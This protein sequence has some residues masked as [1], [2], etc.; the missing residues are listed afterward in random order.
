MRLISWNLAGRKARVSDQVT[1]LAARKPAVVALQEVT[2][3]SMPTLRDTLQ[4][5]GLDNVISSFDLAPDMSL[6]NG[7]R[8]YG[9]LIASP[10]PLIALAP[11]LFDIPWPERVLS[12]LVDYAGCSIELH[13]THIPPGVTNKWIK[14]ETFEGIY[15]R[16]AFE[17][18]TP[19]ILCGDFNSP[20]LELPDGRVVAFGQRLTNEGTVVSQRHRRHPQGRWAQGELSIIQGL[21]EYGM[22]DVYRALHGYKRQDFSWYHYAHRQNGRRF[23][24]VFASPFLN[25]VECQYLHSAREARLSDHSPIEVDFAPRPC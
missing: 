20:Q 23:D 14:I 15:R 22:P 8:R 25:A 11:D 2:A 17:T 13:T 18:A 10:F 19:R 21:A 7:P 24:H 9:Q 3:A 12:V 1:F 16:L 6:L 4:E 5:S